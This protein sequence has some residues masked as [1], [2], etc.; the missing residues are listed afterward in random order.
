M[1]NKNFVKIFLLF[2]IIF[3]PV[4]CSNKKNKPT[5]YKGVV[6]GFYG[7]P[8]T[9]AQRLNMINFMAKTGFNFYLYGPKHDKYHRSRWRIPYPKAKIK[10]LEKVINKCKKN[11]IAFCFAI[12]PGISI[13]YSSATDFALLMKKYNSLYDKGVRFFALFLDDIPARLIKKQDKKRFKQLEHAHTYI[14]NKVFRELKRINPQ[15]NLL[16]VPTHYHGFK[17]GK[18]LRCIGR[19]LNT[20]IP[21]C[22]TGNKIVSP[23]ITCTHLKNITRLLKRKIFLWDNYPVN[24]FKTSSIFLAPITERCKDIKKY[25]SIYCSNPMNQP[26]SSRIPLFT[27]AEW[28]KSPYKYNAEKS[29]KKAIKNTV[30]NYNRDYLNLFSFFTKTRLK[31]EIQSSLGK[32]LIK[33]IKFPKNEKLKRIIRNELNGLKNIIE[34]FQKNNRLMANEL[35]PW[36]EKIALLIEVTKS[37]LNLSYRTK[38]KKRYKEALKLKNRYYK[39]N[40]EIRANAFELFFNNTIKK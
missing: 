7:K 13:T 27:I 29:W 40:Q 6:E 26:L 25:T 38:N 22:W 8:W 5:F 34:D 4:F 39:M 32:K 20:K 31:N 11:N 9:N 35:K 23:Q 1:T 24:D 30:K 18:Y 2:N 12:S 14:A 17:N 16:F 36:L 15:N 28:L 19:N 10:H 37:A 33:L 21:V 3:F